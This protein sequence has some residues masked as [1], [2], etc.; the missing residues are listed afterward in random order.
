MTATLSFEAVQVRATLVDEVAL[1][2]KLVGIEGAV[3]SPADRFTVIVVL[4]MI[5]AESRTVTVITLLPET[6]SILSTFHD[7]VPRAI[8]W[9][10]RLFDQVT[11]LSVLPGATVAVPVSETSA[12]ETLAEP[13]VDGVLIVTVGAV[14]L[15]P[16]G[17]FQNES[18]TVVTPPAP[19]LLLP[20]DEP[21]ATTIKLTDLPFDD[22]LLT[23]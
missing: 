2:V 11:A 20:Q 16:S 10:P 3:M 8:P 9:P 7:V 12:V 22:I 6:R 23:G 18:L 1:A 17:T 13:V 21:V 14:R 5:L 15:A 4:A 19:G